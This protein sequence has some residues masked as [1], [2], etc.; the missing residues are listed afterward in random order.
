MDR[1]AFQR[2]LA[3]L[4]NDQSAGGIQ[5]TCNWTIVFGFA[6]L[7]MGCMVAI[8]ASCLNFVLITPLQVLGLVVGEFVAVVISALFWR[9]RWFGWKR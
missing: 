3:D 4:I 6:S 7:G 2:D 5:E 1:D 8:L 9:R